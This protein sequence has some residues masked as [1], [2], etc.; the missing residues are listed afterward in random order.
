[1]VDVAKDVT[2]MGLCACVCLSLCVCVVLLLS[3]SVKIRNKTKR[4]RAKKIVNETLLTLTPTDAA[5]SPRKAG[6]NNEKYH[7]ENLTSV[8]LVAQDKKGGT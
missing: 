8:I 7:L 6:S 5:H 4:E 2:V 3:L 1:M